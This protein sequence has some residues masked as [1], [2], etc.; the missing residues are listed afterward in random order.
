MNYHEI[1]TIFV[2]GTATVKFA[3]GSNEPLGTPSPSPKEGVDTHEFETII[4]DCPNKAATALAPGGKRKRGGLAEDELQAFS[5]MT[6]AIKDVAQ[7]IRDNTPTDVHRDL[8]QAVM[9]VVEYSHE[10]LMAALSHL[11]DHKRVPTLLAWGT[12]TCTVAQDLP[13]QALL[14]CVVVL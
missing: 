2:G 5:S 7:A 6:E 12:T 9:S 14:Q 4:T 11:I 1:H 8:Y 10:A 3:M 13:V